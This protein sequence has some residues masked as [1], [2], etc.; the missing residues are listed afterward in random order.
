MSFRCLF[1]PSRRVVWKFCE[2]PECQE[3]SCGAL[4]DGVDDDE[5]EVAEDIDTERLIDDDE[6]E[7]AEDIDEEQRVIFGDSDAE[8]LIF[9]DM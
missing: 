9:G 5:A 7:V 1:F 4:F 3:S 8:R 2:F 6:V